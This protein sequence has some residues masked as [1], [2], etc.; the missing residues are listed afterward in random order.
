MP[1]VADETSATTTPAVVPPSPLQLASSAGTTSSTELPAANIL[2][3]V[4]LSKSY[5]EQIS[6]VDSSLLE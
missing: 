4:I 6:N 2:M 5:R 3:L 1:D